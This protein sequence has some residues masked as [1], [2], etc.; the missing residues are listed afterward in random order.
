[1]NSK[2]EKVNSTSFQRHREPQARFSEQKGKTIPQKENSNTEPFRAVFER[3]H[4]RE[5]KK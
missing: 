4:F 1:M 5:G 2:V 3:V